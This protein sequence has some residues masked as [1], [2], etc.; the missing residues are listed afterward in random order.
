MIHLLRHGRT[1][2]NLEGRVQGHTDIP[3]DEEGRK[4]ARLTQSY[5]PR[6][7]AVYASDLRR[8]TETA[9]ILAEPLGLQVSVD[10]RLREVHYGRLEG[11]TWEEIN[12]AWP[13]A[14]ATIAWL[15]RG[16]LPDGEAPLAALARM[17]AAM[18]N[19]AERHPGQEVLVVSHGGVI[20]G[21]MRHVLGV[22][23]GVPSSFRAQNCALARFSGPPWRLEAW[24]IQG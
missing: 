11:R 3:L 2:W 18:E 7:D 14:R 6:V 15:Q 5:L 17:V 13:E 12:R 4:Q 16:E 20:G 23:L 1:A 19:V 9:A 22:P 8:A 24:G 21:F 10:P